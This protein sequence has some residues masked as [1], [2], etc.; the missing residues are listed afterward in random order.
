MNLEKEVLQHFPIIKRIKRLDC[1]VIAEIERSK[2]A[3]TKELEKAMATQIGNYIWQNWQEVV[4]AMYFFSD[5]GDRFC[6]EGTLRTIPSEKSFNMS[7]STLSAEDIFGKFTRFD[8]DV[9]TLS[10]QSNKVEVIFQIDQS[11]P[12]QNINVV[13]QELDLQGHQFY[14][15]A[16]PKP[17]N[18]YF[19]INVEAGID[20]Y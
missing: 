2:N 1:G 9:L 13:F 15:S 5:D 6:L 3:D 16:K 14:I 20:G 7:T 4:Y 17:M 19:A 11:S 10:G 18:G 12:S 8:F